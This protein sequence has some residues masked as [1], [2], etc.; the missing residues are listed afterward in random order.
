[1]DILNRLSSEAIAHAIDLMAACLAKKIADQLDAMYDFKAAIDTKINVLKKEIEHF[2]KQNTEDTKPVYDLDTLP[3]PMNRPRI[4]GFNIAK[5]GI[6]VTP[7]I[8]RALG[9]NPK[10]FSFTTAAHTAVYFSGD[11]TFYYKINPSGRFKKKSEL[12]FY[13]DTRCEN[14]SFIYLQETGNRN[15]F[16][17]K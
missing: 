2:E 15:I 14:G 6:Y 10:S 17:I 13:N 3:K 11:D 8:K 4:Y 1:M 16:K 7:A 9:F 5:S 12:D